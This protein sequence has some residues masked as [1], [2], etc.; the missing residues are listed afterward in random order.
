MAELL[1][2]QQIEARLGELDGWARDGDEISKRFDRGDFVGA[3]EF[4]RRLVDPAE[5][6]GHH[7]DLSISWSEVTVSVTTHSA[8]GLTANDFEL[9]ARIDGLD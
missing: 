3:V 4:V 9:A 7:P 8:G 6:L 2:D 5:E 1:D